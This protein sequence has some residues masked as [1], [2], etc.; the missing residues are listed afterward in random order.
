MLSLQ[1]KLT[2][3]MSLTA[4]SIE[5]YILNHASDQT[6]SIY[7]DSEIITY[8]VSNNLITSLVRGT[9][10]YLVMINFRKDQIKSCNCTCPVKSNIVCKHIVN[11]L[12]KTISNNSK[13]L[14][15]KKIAHIE[16][17]KNFVPTWN[18]TS[19]NFKEPH[20]DTFI[21]Q[22]FS[23]EEVD[24]AF[25]K[26]FATL[27]FSGQSRTS[28]LEIKSLTVNRGVFNRTT[29]YYEYN[30]VECN[31]NPVEKELTLKCGCKDV[32]AVM[33]IHQA[34]IM[35]LIGKSPMYKM[36][37]DAERR[38]EIF[39]NVAQEYGLENESNLEEYFDLKLT[40]YDHYEV[41]LKNKQ[42][43]NFNK[44]IYS[45]NSIHLPEKKK[46]DE[47]SLLVKNYEKKNG[48]VLAEDKYTSGLRLVYF[49]ANTTKSGNLKNP[50]TPINALREMEASEDLSTIRFLSGIL[51]FNG[52]NSES[53]RNDGL[54]EILRPVLKNPM[55][56]P[57]Y[58]HE[59]YISQN[60]TVNSIEPIEIL[61]SSSSF[62]SFDVKVKNNFYELTS[63][64]NI[65]G[66]VINLKEFTKKFGV[67]FRYENQLIY[68]DNKL[69]T[70]LFDFFKEHEFKLLIHESKFEEFNKKYLE[71]LAG[72]VQINYEFIKNASA[73]QLKKSGFAK[74]PNKLIY[75][76]ESENFILLTPAIRYG[77]VEIP[78][79]S[80]QQ[81]NAQDEHGNWFQFDRD[82]D[83]ENEFKRLILNQDKDF[84]KQ[85]KE[86]ENYYIKKSIFYDTGWFID[87]FD[88]WKKNDIEV[89]GFSNLKKRNISTI[90]PDIVVELSSGLDWFDTKISLKFG[91]E[92]I[93]LRSVQK[94]LKK[95][96]NF[97]PLG[98]G[99]FGMLPNEWISRFEKYFRS[100]NI[101]KDGI[102]FSKINF[103]VVEE[104]FKELETGG[105]VMQE[106]QLM[107]QKMTEFQSIQD[108]QVPKNLKATL[109]DYQK[110]GL[111][112][113]NFLDEFNFGGCLADDMGLGKTVQI[114]A[115]ILAQKEKNKGA[116]NL[117]VIPTSL[118]GNWQSELNK[119][120]PSLKLHI[121]YG[122]NRL[123][124]INDF[125]KFDVIITTYGTLISDVKLMNTFVFN[126]VFLDE[127]QAIK[128]P[129]SQRY[130]AVR[131]LK[132][133]NRI[134]LTG[135][136]IE[137][138]T[139]DLYAQMSFVNPSIFG[140]YDKFIAEFSTPIDKH[141]DA[142]RAKELA[143]RINPFM[144]RRT[145]KQVA[146][147]L[148]DKTEVVLH[149]EMGAE[150]R[151]IYDAYKLKIRAQLVEETQGGQKP[152]KINGLQKRMII[153]QGL[154]KLRQIC[155]SPILLS[156]EEDYGNNSAKIEVLMEEI[157][158]KHKHH[159]ILVFS[160]FVGMLNLIRKQLDDREI[161]HE[162]LTG[163]TKDR[164]ERVHNFQNDDEIRVFLISLKAGGT[165]LNLTEADYVYLVDP[166]WNPAAENQA[167]DRC[168]RIGQ[169]KNVVAVRLITPNSIE[170]KI[171]K[172]QEGKKIM[173]DDIIQTDA[174][175][176]KSLSQTDLVSLFD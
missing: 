170:E 78:I 168:Y 68:A 70:K 84:E 174:S 155:N 12:K 131:L 103:T 49:E 65:D 93:S 67:F 66:K 83:L 56:L 52:T 142:Q 136:P 14:P 96:E 42:V 9:T 114:I 28:Y 24:E 104:L 46:F 16:V 113:L 163:Q 8:S 130:K 160:Q 90:K 161:S 85:D 37:F 143:K 100:G 26:H 94:A 95:K 98:D 47:K 169:K 18:A 88:L 105:E 99:S 151:K 108:C 63:F 73:K 127:S 150:Q 32:K 62:L 82:L 140:S 149:C 107:K 11:V 41:V 106:I 20:L 166:W 156:D 17:S 116:T 97:V 3:T 55:Q 153:I 54:R 109:R 159:K 122:F 171:L 39:R 15:A 72:N 118:I 48:L 172:L 5:T 19:P 51:A 132:A 129:R 43:F 23:W 137:N 45:N 22:N 2:T 21:F 110:Q 144:L 176:M 128:N 33:C 25:I 53:L 44:N 30:Q 7:K 115:F 121:N 35:R 86:L 13:I 81:I 167:I 162:Y 123:K 40:H 91:E 87:A 60:I 126:Y 29:S 139:T 141:K 157:E 71:P 117:I 1:P 152:K 69:Y 164:A 138:Y 92:N 80:Q 124:E 50:L 147:E 101:T 27:A 38:L 175:A 112:W 4:N 120:A 89:L 146:T 59:S 154:T 64:L 125:S 57:I 111:N 102:E 173:A 148:P 34:M 77:K 31:F 76:T 58:L 135:T 75:L 133:R 145:K 10:N 79:R 36:F 74:S 6:I 165:G 134:V 61:M 158:T 119:F